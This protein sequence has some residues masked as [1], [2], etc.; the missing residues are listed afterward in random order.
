MAE[1]N[2]PL[3]KHGRINITT[4]SYQT[5]LEITADPNK[6]LY[7]RDI[8]INLSAVAATT[9]IKLTINGQ[10]FLRDFCPAALEVKLSF[11]G[12]LVFHGKTVKPPILIEVKDSAGIYVTAFVTGIETD[13]KG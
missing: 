7:I 8:V 2:L 10:P 3:L 12:D 4:A 13:Y 6:S 11:G 1:S 5:L 9:F